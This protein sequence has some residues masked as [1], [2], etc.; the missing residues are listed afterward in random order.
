[1]L[2]LQRPWQGHKFIDKSEPVCQPSPLATSLYTHLKQTL[3][4]PLP[5]YTLYNHYNT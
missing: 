4:H 1:M 2:K 5:S 3:L